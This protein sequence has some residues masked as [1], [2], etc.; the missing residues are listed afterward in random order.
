MLVIAPEVLREIEQAA[1]AATP[2]AACG[3]LVGRGGLAARVVTAARPARPHEKKRA[4]GVHPLDYQKI[5]EEARGQGLDVLGFYYCDAGEPEE[6]RASAGFEGYSYLVGGLGERGVQW[7]A[8]ERVDDDLDE[9]ELR[10]E[11]GA[12]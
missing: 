10:V 2:E 11:P 6:L 5:D 8:L 4:F 3:L 12:G 7:L 1:V 9:E